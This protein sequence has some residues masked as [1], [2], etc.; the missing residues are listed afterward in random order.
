MSKYPLK[1][2]HA[3]NLR[4]PDLFNEVFDIL[5]QDIGLL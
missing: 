3:L 2:D 1:F 5:E 4:L